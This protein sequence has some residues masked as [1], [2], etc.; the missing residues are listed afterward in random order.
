MSSSYNCKAFWVRK[1]VLEEA[2]KLG[3]N[4]RLS[5]VPGRWG[6]RGAVGLGWERAWRARHC[7]QALSGPPCAKRG[8]PEAPGLGLHDQGLPSHA[9]PP[10]ESP[11]LVQTGSSSSSA[12]VSAGSLPS[13]QKGRKG[14]RPPTVTSPWLESRQCATEMPSARSC[15][16]SRVC[17]Y[18]SLDFTRGFQ[19]GREL[20]R[21]VPAAQDFPRLCG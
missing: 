1:G 20:C 15:V 16:R 10:P 7:S 18:S 21:I 12:S 5:R 14:A 8:D 13:S 2:K 11:S 3:A 19:G 17:N 9:P 4:S 6:P